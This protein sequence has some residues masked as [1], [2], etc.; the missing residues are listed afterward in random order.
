[1]QLSISLPDTSLLG[2][3]IKSVKETGEE[4]KKSFSIVGAALFGRPPGC[5]HLL[6]CID[7]FRPLLVELRDLLVFTACVYLLF[8]GGVG[9]TSKTR[10]SAYGLYLKHTG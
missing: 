10:W 8:F 7:S 5:L 2:F 3:E 6:V 4:G 1:M 9:L